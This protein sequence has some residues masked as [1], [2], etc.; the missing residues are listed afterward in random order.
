MTPDEIIA[1]A[2][3]LYANPTFYPMGSEPQVSRF[4]RSLVEM[5]QPDIAVELGTHLGHSMLHM[6]AG[7]PPHGRL[8]TIDNRDCRPRTV[9]A[10]PG[11]TFIKANSVDGIAQL[12]LGIGL[13]FIDTVHEYDFLMNEVRALLPKL[14]GNAILVLHDAIAFPDVRRAAMSMSR[15]RAIVLPTPVIPERDAKVKNHGP[16]GLA[17]LVRV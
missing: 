7:M 4:L 13:V 16:A 2:H 17:V 9:K 8:F 15:F 12:P 3:S 14:T 6:L 5:V 11:Y 10:V 1:V